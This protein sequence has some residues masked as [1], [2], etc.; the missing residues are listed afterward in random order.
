MLPR[1]PKAVIFD[2][3]GLILDSEI[4]YRKS[5]ISAGV[6]AGLLVG[7]SIYEGMLGRPWDGIVHLLK[8]HYGP[9]FDAEA[10][11]AVWVDH[12]DRLTALELKLKAGVVALLDTLDT[13]AIP[14]AICTSSAHSQ[15]QH[16]LAGFGIRERFDHVIAL[17]DYARGKPAPDPYLTAAERLGIAPGDCLALEDSHNG[18]RSAASAGMMAVMVPDLLAPTDE[19]RA[20]ATLVIDD[21]HQCC[22]FFA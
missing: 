17:G 10:F 1:T 20:L 4:L 16:H 12:F 19:I 21:L 15:V 22:G 3:D 14:R 8:D 6:Q 5:V 9:D 11:R 7:P 18:I 13:K 2:M